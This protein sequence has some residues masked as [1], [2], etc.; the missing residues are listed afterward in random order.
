MKVLELN[1]SAVDW[2][3]GPARAG[4]DSL[5]DFDGDRLGF[6]TRAA[7]E[8]GDFV[9]FRLG[10]RQAVLVNR[11]EFIEE[12][13]VSPRSKDFSKDYL[14][15]LIP[16]L[17]R[18]HLLLK[19]ADS[20]LVE[21]RMAQPAFHH[22]RLVSYAKVM[23]DEADRMVSGWAD[24]D[25]IDVLGASR[26]LTLNILC[27][28][29]FDV[30]ISA[31]SRQAAALIDLLLN[32]IDARVTRQHRNLARLRSAPEDLKLLVRLVRIERML[33]DLIRER[34]SDPDHRPDLLSRL[35]KM[36]T[37]DGSLVDSSR[38]R[39]VVVPLFFAGHET[40]AV[41]LAWTLFLIVLHPKTQT[42]VRE[43]LDR[44]LGDRAVADSD[45]AS[46]TYL[47]SVVMESLRLY[48]PIWGFGRQAVQATRVGP[49]VV[50]EGTIVWMSQWVMHRDSRWFEHPDDFIPE[51]W[52]D[53]LPK[54]LPKCVF[55]PFGA[56]SR[57]CLGGTYAVWE[58]TLVLATVLRRFRLDL[59]S[60]VE[61]AP[62]PSFTLR[63]S[64]GLS[65]IVREK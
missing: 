1:R 49:Y 23:R 33:D 60:G 39:Y 15:E 57:R 22:E 51:R 61:I 19:D 10:R 12:I 41:S 53:G 3:S 36:A 25:R 20:W 34:R 4:G 11:P 27:R 63:P 55:S 65:M 44:V 56:G 42:K 40:T 30:D 38:V 14:T 43:E 5:A 8:F 2:P 37:S 17:V 13:L 50:P 64:K 35:A 45:I 47:G 46:L 54:R 32:Q 24:G 31:L 52:S 9:P 21:R 48:P 18:R 6:L 26:R 62:Q 58:T 59:D 16:P 29:L 7:Q 28:T